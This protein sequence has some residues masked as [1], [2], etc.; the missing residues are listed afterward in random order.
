[1]PI[2]RKDIDKPEMRYKAVS[3]DGTTRAVKP[4]FNRWGIVHFPHQFTHIE[5]V[6]DRTELWGTVKFENSDNP[7]DY[8]LIPSFAYGIDWRKGGDG[9]G[10]L[11]WLSPGLC[12]LRSWSLNLV[13]PFQ[14]LPSA[15]LRAASPARLPR[16]WP[17][18]T[19]T[20]S[21]DGTM[22]TLCPPAPA[23]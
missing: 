5:Q 13:L 18:R 22:M 23:M 2:L 7:E 10:L 3:H 15:T 6:G 20:R 16:E 19:T 21:C 14:Y 11:P 1:M 17:N 12:F 8:R 4:L 9:I